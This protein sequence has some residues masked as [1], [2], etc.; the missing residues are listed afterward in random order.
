MD[1]S[2]DPLE[3][4]AGFPAAGEDEWRAL[5][6]GVLRRSGRGD[7]DDPVEALTSTTYDGIRI[8]PLYA[9]RPAEPGLPGAPP[10]VRGALPDRTGWDVRAQHRDPD[11]RS[12]CAAGLTDL[13]GG[14]TSLWLVLGADGVA[15][16]DL[17]AAL[18]GVH[19]D[20]API[21]LDAG[22]QTGAAATAFLGLARDVDPGAVAGTLGADPIGLQARTGTVAEPGLLGDLARAAR[23]HPQLHVATIDATVYHEAGAGDADELA[24]ATAVGVAYLRALTDA[25]LSI[26][27]AL[28]AVEFRFAVTADQFLS[29]AKLRAARRLWARVAELSGVVGGRGQYQH[30]VTSAAMMTRRDPWVNMLRTTIACFA[31]AIGGADAIT[32]LPFD[33]AIGLPDSFARR[34]ARNTQAILHDESSLGRVV[35][36]AGGSSYVEAL[37]A[38]L[39]EKAWDEF[40]AIERA[41][42]ALA[43]L[44]GGRIEELVARSRSA[45]A[46]DIAHR[47]FSLI[48]VSEFAL[49]DE[50][51]VPRTPGPA[52]ATGGPLPSLR[53][54][55][56]FE[57][58]RDRAEAVEPRPVVFL[59]ALGPLA[60]HS[61]RVGFAT[62]LFNAAGL[63]TRVGPVEDFADSG[64]SVACLC[65]SDEVYTELG[66]AA[67]AQLRGAGAAHI[68]LAGRR[69]SVTGVDG[70]VHAGCDALEVLKTTLDLSLAATP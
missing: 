68:W 54:A 9:D 26:E 66:D 50:A 8:R 60:A 16:D 45:R 27:A 22:A 62:N 28:R 1:A 33:A 64:A 56:P 44:E 38:E 6:A 65:S 46:Q 18:Q 4:A 36:A 12:T 29:I 49:P 43:A 3:L 35:D 51:P 69:G 47:R 53:Y 20:L 40:T 23:P 61:A 48:G 15:V 67:V 17:H 42:G 14:A 5:V 70:F 32:V 11:P 25:G 39:A 24:V 57:A 30:A 58:L 37:T 10:Y 59:A 31:A 7:L 34:I 19:L 63:R 52:R 2:T 41:G 13:Q 21:A 55:E